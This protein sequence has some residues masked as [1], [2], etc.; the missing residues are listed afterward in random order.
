MSRDSIEWNDSLFA[1]DASETTRPNQPGLIQQESVSG[2]KR[3]H[4]PVEV[5]EPLKTKVCGLVNK[6]NT[7]YANSLIRLVAQW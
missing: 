1:E 5:A 7:C 6:G 2:P 3:P 4:K